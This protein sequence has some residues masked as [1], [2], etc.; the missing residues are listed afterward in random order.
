METNKK[1]M[2]VGYAR[3]SS[4]DQNLDR[5]RE[6]LGRYGVDRLYEDKKSGKDV[7]REQF[8]AMMDF[9]R[10]GDTIVVSELSRMNR[11]IIDLYKTIDTLNNKGVSVVFI[12]EGINTSGAYNKLILAIFAGLAEFERENIRDRQAEGITL[13]KKA[14]K[15]KG[16]PCKKFD[17]D[18]LDGL[19]ADLEKGTVTVVDA[20]K[21]LGVSRSTLYRIIKN[22]SKEDIKP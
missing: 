8:R 6:A 12:K 15:Y 22:I 2:V 21:R 19:R 4:T 10:E 17:K 3:V 14:G 20:A 16:R 11:N 9:V 13:A 7:D 18:V 1:G 5:Q